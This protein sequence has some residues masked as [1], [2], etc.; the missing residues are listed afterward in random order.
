M[1]I[2]FFTENLE[3]KIS[4]HWSLIVYAKD[5]RNWLTT[6]CAIN[7]DWPSIILL[8]DRSPGERASNTIN[9]IK[10]L[11]TGPHMPGKSGKP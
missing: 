6:G 7:R 11:L 10:S 5:G 9:K 1:H 8:F 2:K 4:R 3:Q